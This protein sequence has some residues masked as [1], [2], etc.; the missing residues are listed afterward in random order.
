VR[1]STERTN[2]IYIL[3][4]SPEPEVGGLAAKLRHVIE[5]SGIEQVELEDVKQWIAIRQNREVPNLSLD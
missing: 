4:W 1:L 2:N 3:R 5:H